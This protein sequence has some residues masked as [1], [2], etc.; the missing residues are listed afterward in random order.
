MRWE[1]AL[2]PAVALLSPVLVNLAWPWM[3][4]RLIDRQPVGEAA[5]RASAAPPRPG[6]VA[7]DPA[8]SADP[9]ASRQGELVLYLRSFAPW[10]HGIGP[11][12]LALI[13]GTIF[14]RDFGIARLP[15]EQWLIGALLCGLWI[16]VTIRYVHPAGDW[17]KPARGV[18]DEPRWA[19]YRAAGRAWVGS[20][21]WGAL[22]GLALA[23]GELG[24]RTLT[25]GGGR[26][27]PW[28]G[29]ARAASSSV[30]FALT[31]SFWLTVLTQG[32]LL[33]ALRGRRL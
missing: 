20:Q 19:L 30:L 6:E 14:E 17:P 13:T 23:L 1:T 4:T 15:L 21:P 33:Y 29:V 3:R 24:L 9:T 8:R 28:E 11:A 10:L 2:W 18:L 32:A 26:A 27:A 25:G 31:G 12:Y 22:L 7:H 5:H 16:A